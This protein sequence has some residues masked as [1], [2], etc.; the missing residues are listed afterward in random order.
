MIALSRNSLCL[1]LLDET[2]YD[3]L[4][5]V[6]ACCQAREIVIYRAERFI[7][8]NS[9]LIKRVLTS[10]YLRSGPEH[11]LTSPFSEPGPKLF[12]TGGFSRKTFPYQR[13]LALGANEVY[14]WCRGVYDWPFVLLK[15]IPLMY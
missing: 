8:S 2:T 12:V 14:I 3:F 7:T 13:F 10:N 15:L 11:F 1:V 4:R 5:L 9:P 6:L